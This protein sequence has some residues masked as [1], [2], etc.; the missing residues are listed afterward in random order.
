L[1]WETLSNE[2]L[3]KHYGKGSLEAFDVFFKR[4]SK[5]I[6]LFIL[7]RVGEQSKAEDILQETFIRLHKYI[8]RYDS[9]R[10]ALNWVF[11]IAKNQ[12]YTQISKRSDHAEL[13]ESL[14]EDRKHA[15]IEARDEL[16]KIL[17]GL[18]EEERSLLVDKFLQEE[19]YEEMSSKRSLTPVN[20]R[21]KVSRILKKIRSGTSL[22]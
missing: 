15:S 8:H 12:M 7:S 19:S 18:D 1:K 9:E 14:V 22:D 20:T 4:N 21:Q 17:S 16:G 5:A 13:D 6:F 10:N 3:L 2:D 11:T